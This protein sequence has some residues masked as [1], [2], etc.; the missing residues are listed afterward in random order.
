MVNGP[1]QQMQLATLQDHNMNQK[2]IEAQM[3]ALAQQRD[4]AMNNVVNLVGEIARLNEEI[5]SLKASKE[6]SKDVPN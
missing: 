1:L 2:V 4:A 6:E 3:Q 5:K